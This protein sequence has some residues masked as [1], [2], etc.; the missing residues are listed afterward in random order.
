MASGQNDN[1]R[2]QPENNFTDGSGAIFS[3]F[4]ERAEKDDD[5]MTENWKGDAD[6]ILVF[7]GLFSATVATFLGISLQSLTQNS[8]DT[9]AFY[10]ARIY[11]SSA[12]D[13]GNTSASIPL[14]PLPDPSSFSPSTS[15]IWVNVLWLLS[16]VI[17]LTCALLATL[18]QQWARR[19]LRLAR[20]ACALH[21]RAR[22][23]NYLKEGVDKFYLPSV[24][25][26]LPG[27]LHASVFLFFIGLSV[28]LAGIN[29]IVF[30]AIVSCISAS[31]G[32]Y[33]LAS[34]IPL[35]RHDTPYHT[36]LSTLF[37]VSDAWAQWALF[38]IVKYL[39]R[40]SPTSL[41][42][43]G[44]HMSWWD[45]YLV[46]RGGFMG[47]FTRWK[48]HLKHR[49]QGMGKKIER[50]ALKQSPDV[51]ARAIQS[52]ILTLD[53][54]HEIERLIAGIPDF[55]KS[56][57]VPRPTEV[58]MGQCVSATDLGGLILAF[59]ERSSSDTV[60]ESVAARR[61]TLCVKAFEAERS[62]LHWRMLKYYLFVHP[63]SAKMI[64]FG[65]LAAAFADDY[66]DPHMAR[67]FRLVVAKFTA[68]IGQSD[69]R[70]FHAMM[71]QLG[72]D[73]PTLW[74]YKSHGGSLLL[75]NLLQYI[76][77]AILGL[78]RCIRDP[79]EDEA[80]ILTMFQIK[81]TL[82][83]LQHEFCDTW[84]AALSSALG[85][86]YGLDH[87]DILRSNS[88]AALEAICS[89]FRTLHPDHDT[90]I[91]I[92]ESVMP[93]FCTDPQHAPIYARRDH[94]ALAPSSTD[95]SSSSTSNNQLSDS[96]T[97]SSADQDHSAT[98]SID[99]SESLHALFRLTALPN[100]PSP[101]DVSA[102]LHETVTAL[103]VDVDQRSAGLASI[104]E[105]S[106]PHGDNDSVIGLPRPDSS[107]VSSGP[108]DSR[109]KS[110]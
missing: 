107:G 50:T 56:K 2:A 88:L 54:D 98:P 61:G 96:T 22:I 15:A 95:L 64:N 100:S 71:D 72:V 63:P 20:P 24:V 36:P 35:F 53:E 39:Y 16:L 25:E 42:H 19:Y 7:T 105:P 70:W 65:L 5:R 6:G 9:S 23:R 90:H 106:L 83:E 79:E 102:I 52:F 18:L 27:L 92:G 75:A 85:G 51:D 13:S 67:Y 1:P 74:Q 47:L 57:A 14:P 80:I 87:D 11:Q 43:L 89:L 46:A 28:F 38:R 69:P 48:I 86:N 21:K 41:Y 60:P 93:S 99:F 55:C 78:G 30:T 73:E 76:R 40:P 49:F 12:A 66:S 44:A 34:L 101:S 97:S 4:L 94:L 81:N 26:A 45:D 31:A 10:L 17:S 103:P 109:E 8:Q 62:M 77:G 84:N 3:F 32:L 58:L 108:V 59:M 68:K 37:W 110:V 29:N 33:L 91:Q 104:P 82:P